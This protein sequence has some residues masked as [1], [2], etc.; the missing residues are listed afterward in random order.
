[1]CAY[2][3]TIPKVL[4]NSCSDRIKL[5][6]LLRLSLFFKAELLLQV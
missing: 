4:L 6:M 5:D 1:M 2:R 3:K